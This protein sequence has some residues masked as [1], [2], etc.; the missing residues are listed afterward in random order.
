MC[1]I[2]TLNMEHSAIKINIKYPNK[3]PSQYT[4]VQVKEHIK[5]TS[6]QDLKKEIAKQKA[7]LR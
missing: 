2:Y 1:T 7:A 5:N 6:Q 4:Y 3:H